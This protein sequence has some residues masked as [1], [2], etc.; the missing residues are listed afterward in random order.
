MYSPVFNKIFILRGKCNKNDRKFSQGKIK[1]S[2]KICGSSC[3]GT[4]TRQVRIT[5]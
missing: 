5:L 1:K 2:I 3:A 4:V